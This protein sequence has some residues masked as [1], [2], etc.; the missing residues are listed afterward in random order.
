[1]RTIAKFVLV[2][3]LA[4]ATASVGT[5]TDPSERP[6]VANLGAEIDLEAARQFW[7]FQPLANEGLPIVKDTSWPQAPLDFYVLAA[8]EARDLEPA[9]PTDVIPH[10]LPILNRRFCRPADGSSA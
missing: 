10:T 9:A 6:A 2:P 5:E 1:M 7:A 4:G 3:V 8:L